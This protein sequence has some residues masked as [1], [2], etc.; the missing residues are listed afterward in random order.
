M[1]SSQ[2]LHVELAGIRLSVRTDASRE[3]V[4]AIV[5]DIERRLSRINEQAHNTPLNRRLILATLMLGED[6]HNAKSRV[7]EKQAAAEDAEQTAREKQQE[8]AESKSKV[9]QLQKALDSSRQ[10]NGELKKRVQSLTEELDTVRDKLA[11]ER[12]RAED[13]EAQMEELEATTAAS[14]DADERVRELQ[15]KVEQRDI[16]LAEL[17][18]LRA[19][20]VDR[21]QTALE[22][23]DGEA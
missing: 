7:D 1:S 23:V 12:K 8:A 11:S 10:E 18:K 20:V 13:A 6:L 21:A 3:T 14:P 9:E 16:R 22:L 2:S 15:T 4:D 19:T 17:E 5:E